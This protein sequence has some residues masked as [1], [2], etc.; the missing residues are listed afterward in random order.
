[1]SKAYFIGSG[2]SVPFGL[3]SVNELS[4][5]IYQNNSYYYRHTSGIYIK[6]RSTIEEKDFLINKIIKIT[7][8]FLKS[9]ARLYHIDDPAYED[10]IDCLNQ[11][12]YCI[13]G[14]YENPS[15][16][17]GFYNQIFNLVSNKEKVKIILSEKL[18]LITFMIR[19]KLFGEQENITA[20]I[21][22]FNCK[23]EGKLFYDADFIFTLNHDL[24]IEQYLTYYNV[25]FDEG[26]YPDEYKLMR[27]NFQRFEEAKDKIKLLKLHGS[28]NYYYH[29]Q[30]IIKTEDPFYI[31]DPASNG[32]SDNFQPTI[33][34]G[35][36]SKILN[37]SKYFYSAIHSYFNYLLQSEVRVLYVIGYGFKDKGIN[38][39]LISWYSS[40]VNRKI[41]IIDPAGANLINTSRP[42]IGRM[43]DQGIQ[44]KRITII[45]K[46]LTDFCKQDCKIFSPD[47]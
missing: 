14:E 39:F 13:S 4:N 35:K 26:F 10:I 17:V 1:M 9:S 6:G 43:L 27:Y 29:D 30:T 16:D 5:Y 34:S 41:I 24:I 11:Y 2:F 44:L 8:N 28:L 31:P 20:M 12:L 21:N 47:L 42:A 40:D 32:F 25:D 23:T 3:P 7:Y 18:A 22:D 33:L 15:L 45:D 19:D 38:N 37:Y 46:S 36:I